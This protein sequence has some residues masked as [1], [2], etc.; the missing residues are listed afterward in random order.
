MWSSR[1]LVTSTGSRR[2]DIV[3]DVYVSIKSVK[4]FNVQGK[5]IIA[6]YMLKSWNKLLNV[7]ANKPEIGKCLVPQCNTDAFRGRLGNWI[8]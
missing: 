3:F 2:I 8:M 6:A 7:I 5:N 1:E 4:S